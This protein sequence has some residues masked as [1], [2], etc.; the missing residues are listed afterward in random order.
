MI[1]VTL[2]SL[3]GQPGRDQQGVVILVFTLINCEWEDMCLSL[4]LLPIATV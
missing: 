1:I 2:F 3:P 4:I